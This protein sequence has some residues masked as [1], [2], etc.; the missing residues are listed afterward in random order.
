MALVVRGFSGY[1]NVARVQAL[2]CVK[3]VHTSKRAPHVAAPCYGEGA[4]NTFMVLV[5]RDGLMNAL[6][7]IETRAHSHLSKSWAT[8][9]KQVGALGRCTKREHGRGEKG[10][11]AC[12][13]TRWAAASTGTVLRIARTGQS[14]SRQ[15]CRRKSHWPGW[16]RLARSA[17]LPFPPARGPRALRARPARHAQALVGV[18]VFHLQRALGCLDHII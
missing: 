2:C 16:W 10:S 7:S 1:K 9:H 6:H 14:G 4:V 3:P 15:C 11:I 8:V 12:R 13:F 5:R 18:E 17:W